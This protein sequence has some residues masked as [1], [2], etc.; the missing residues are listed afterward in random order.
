M[1]NKKKL[2]TIAIAAEI[3]PAKTIIPIIKKIKLLE[4]KNK[5]NW[6][7]SKIIGLYHGDSVK[8]ILSPF[9]DECFSIG[10]G[11]GSNKKKNSNIKLAYLIFKDFLKAFSAMRGKNIDLL[12]TAGNAGDVRKSI[13]A[14]NFLHIPVIHIEQDIYNPIEI[15]SHANLVTVPSEKYVS[16]L[17]NH[18]NLS[19]VI[20]IGGYPMVSYVID[21]IKS[22]KNISKEQ[23][24]SE[25]GL[26]LTDDYILLVLGGDLRDNDLERLIRVCESLNYLIIIAPYRFDKHLVE[27]LV[28]SSNINVLDNYVDLYNYLSNAKI[29]IYAAGMGMTIEA[30]IFE[31]PSIKIKGFHKD[32]AS[33][34]L[35][36]DLNIPI[37]DIDDIS[38]VINHLSKSNSKDLIENSQ[39]AIDNLIDII[40]N[41]FNFSFNKSGLSST[42]K[43]WNQR[44]KYR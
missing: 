36:N 12:I 40:I 32:H 13:L 35:A 9:C 29:L 41:N 5:L 22:H 18:Y 39:I 6:E 30:G 43:I 3:T 11:R 38:H 17:K 7:N 42:K 23:I 37:V 34:D 15:I 26:K 1:S 10:Q 16:Y 2:M 28:N 20:N 24:L 21:S 19:N 31:I 27:S 25:N 33:V 44:K 4:S 14:A 8:N